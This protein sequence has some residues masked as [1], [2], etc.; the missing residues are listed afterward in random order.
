MTDKKKEK[1]VSM[2]PGLA[3][4]ACIFIGIMGVALAFVTGEA[5]WLISSAIAFGS[6]VIAAFQ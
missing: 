4:M 1:K 5:T 2:L 3:I 6:I